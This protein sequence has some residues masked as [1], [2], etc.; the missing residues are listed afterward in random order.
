MVLGALPVI[1]GIPFY[2]ASKRR[3]SL[4]SIRGRMGP[5]ETATGD[6]S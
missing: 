1:A 3:P 4:A 5:T 2:F 6:E